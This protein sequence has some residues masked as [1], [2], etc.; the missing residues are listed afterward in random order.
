MVAPDLGVADGMDSVTGR[1]REVLYLGMHTRYQV[2][3]DG[4]GDLTV[5]AQNIDGSSID[6]LAARGRHVRLLWQR[7]HNQAIGDAAG[8]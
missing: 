7:K 3:L 6:T 5:V 1:I 4:G 2:A 8:G